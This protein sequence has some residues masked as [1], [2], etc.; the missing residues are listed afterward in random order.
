VG[1][2]AICDGNTNTFEIWRLE[3]TDAWYHAGFGPAFFGDT[4]DK[5]NPSLGHLVQ[6]HG[7]GFN[8]SFCDGHAEFVKKSKL[9]MWTIR[10]G[11]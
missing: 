3:Q 8:A 10:S 4:P 9:G 6:R 1:T 7:E 5:K 11:D 2:I